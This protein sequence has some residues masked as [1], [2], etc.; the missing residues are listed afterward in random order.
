[1]LRRLLADRTEITIPR[2]SETV[3]GSSGASSKL[4]A[5]NAQAPR[6]ACVCTTYTT[7]AG[8]MMISPIP[9]LTR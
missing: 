9:R 7:D 4:A 5:K 1:M 8:V 6:P 2:A 3:I